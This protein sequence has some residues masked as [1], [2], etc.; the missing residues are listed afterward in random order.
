MSNELG[1]GKNVTYST[2]F[3]VYYTVSKLVYQILKQIVVNRES[4]R[5]V[6]NGDGTCFFKCRNQSG[7]VTGSKARNLMFMI[8]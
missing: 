6:K 1:T 7:A 4:E 5:F 8:F 2:S 3:P